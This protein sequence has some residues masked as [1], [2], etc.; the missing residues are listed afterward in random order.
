[1]KGIILLI[2]RCLLFA[3]FAYAGM[4]KTMDVSSFYHDIRLYHLLPDE[5]AWY[6]AHYLPWLEMA[7]GA[8]LMIKCTRA[9]SCLIISLLLLVFMGA[10]VSAW[11]RGFNI[12]C[13]CFGQHLSPS[14]YLW[15]LLRDLAMFVGAI[16][17]LKSTLPKAPRRATAIPSN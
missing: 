4:V 12:E 14:N 7:A 13:G 8:G 11:L 5:A 17:L 9:S 16:Y 15:I 2:I 10:A 3:I 6:W 1:M